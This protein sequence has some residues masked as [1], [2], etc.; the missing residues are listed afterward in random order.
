[1][2]KQAFNPNPQMPTL[3]QPVWIITENSLEDKVTIVGERGLLNSL[4]YFAAD[5]IIVR[6]LGYELKNNDNL[7]KIIINEGMVDQEDPK[8]SLE[9]HMDLAKNFATE[10]TA[11]T[12]FV[13]EEVAQNVA[14]KLNQNQKGKCKLLLDL[15]NKAYNTYDD[16]IAACKVI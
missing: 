10:P 5:A 4:V 16:I 13:N 8:K 14:I 12:V 2:S 11:L 7:S 9:I 3:G 15:A 6:S 1:M